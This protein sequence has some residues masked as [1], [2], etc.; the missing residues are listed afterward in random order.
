ME[1]LLSSER[2]TLESPFF[3]RDA[4]QLAIQLLGKILAVRHSGVWLMARII[5]TEA[6]YQS[7]MASHSSL[8]YTE[9]RKALFMPAGTIY[10]YYARGGDSLNFSASGEGNA[11]LIK[12]A[13]PVASRELDQKS[14]IAMQN[15]NPQADGSPRPLAKLC[16]GQTLLCKALSLKVPDWD[17]QRLKSGKFEVLDD[18]YRPGKVIQTR[19]LG[20]H[21]QR[22]ALLPLR[23]IDYHF[24]KSC[25]KNPLTVRNWQIGSEYTILKP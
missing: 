7:D 17:G 12:S 3:N 9:K 4:Q 18:T 25:T 6:Y 22:D 21:P 15:N 11:V 8:G 1:Y 5:E 2:V 14:T 16:S 23:F 24:A 13:Y 19:R 10:M 20:I